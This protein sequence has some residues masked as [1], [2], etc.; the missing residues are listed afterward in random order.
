M[1]LEFENKLFFSSGI[2]PMNLCSRFDPSK[3]RLQDELTVP[4][5]SP[6][7]SVVSDVARVSL[8]NP[9]NTSKIRPPANLAEQFM[10]HSLATTNRPQS[11]SLTSSGVWAKPRPETNSKVTL[12][13]VEFSHAVINLATELVRYVFTRN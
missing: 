12:R 8:E 11:S 4:K 7:T 6:K 3:L 1:L 10:S 9:L 13:P 2:R 5:S